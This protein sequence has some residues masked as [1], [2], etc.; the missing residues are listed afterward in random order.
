M[1]VLIYLIFFDRQRVVEMNAKSNSDVTKKDVTDTEI[2]A[3]YNKATSTLLTA[4]E[5]G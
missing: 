3:F 4:L 1:Y 2:L 5:V